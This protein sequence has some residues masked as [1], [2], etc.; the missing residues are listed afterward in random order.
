LVEHQVNGRELEPE[1]AKSQKQTVL[2]R[3]AI[4]APAV[5]LRGAVQAAMLLHPL[6]APRR[7]IEKRHHAKRPPD[8]LSQAAPDRLPLGEL[9]LEP[10]VGIQNEIPA[11]YQRTLPAVT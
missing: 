6:T 3:H 8:R 5:V 4:E 1:A 2:L 11:A 9:R 7:G 10:V